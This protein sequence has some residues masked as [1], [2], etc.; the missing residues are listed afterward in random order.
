LWIFR[1]S[2]DTFVWDAHEL[3]EKIGALGLKSGVHW[4]IATTPKVTTSG[5]KN[6]VVPLTRS[7]MARRSVAL[8]CMVLEDGAT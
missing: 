2:I 4:P 8:S 5:N 3:E 1:V 7:E 6:K